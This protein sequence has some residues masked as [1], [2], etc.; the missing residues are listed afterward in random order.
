M[1]MSPKGRTARLAYQPNGLRQLSPGDHVIC[2]M[3]GAVIMLED[4]RY[5]SV[6]RQEPYATAALAVEAISGRVAAAGA[7]GAA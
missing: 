4:L 5:W 6:D 3:S 2:A 7:S 1:L